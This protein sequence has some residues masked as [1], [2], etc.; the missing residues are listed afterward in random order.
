MLRA[1]KYVLL[2]LYLS[3]F[4]AYSALNNNH[5]NMRQLLMNGVATPTKKLWNLKNADIRSVI[6]EV[7]QVTGKNFIIVPKVQGKISIVSSTPI[8]NHELYQVFLSMLQVSGFA[9]IPSG[10]VIKIIPNIDSRAFFNEDSSKNSYRLQGDDM[11]V[12]VVPVHYVPAEQLVPV[13]RPL[14]P[15][16]SNVAAYG[17]S[18]RL[19]LS[20]RANNIRQMANIIKQVD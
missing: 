15:Q 18:N 20:G 11:L 12:L 6:A 4:Q 19:I 3:C 1:S 5:P 16:W 7:A 2:L 10:N 13:L 14:M 8:N 17:P 9:A